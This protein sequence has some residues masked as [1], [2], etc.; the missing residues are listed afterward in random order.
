MSA[1]T[2]WTLAI[3]GLLGGNLLAMGIIAFTAHAKQAQII[4]AYDVAAAHHDDT[5]AEAERSHALGWSA[6]VEIR[7]GMAVVRVVDA[8][9]AA[10]RD[11]RVRVLGYPRAHAIDRIEVALVALG[12]GTHQAPL[13]ATGWHDLTIVVE[14]GD[15][16]F[17]QRA[18]VEA[19]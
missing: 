14:R 3:L 1:K 5:M 9:G 19:R 18:V 10:L 16:A 8:T 7:A 2:N 13:R 6:T 11:A 4:P 12:D 15:E 17:S